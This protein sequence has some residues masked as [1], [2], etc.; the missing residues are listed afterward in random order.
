MFKKSVLIILL[1][2]SS[3][4]ISYDYNTSG[5]FKMS[6][7]KSW[8]GHIDVYFENGEQHK[9]PHSDKV[10]FIADPLKDYH[11]SLLYAAYFSGKTVQLAYSCDA[12]NAPLIDG[13]RVR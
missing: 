5:Y 4:S 12:N 8:D 10:R 7:V 1:A 6:E 3:Y 2:M 9:C 11:V 13:V